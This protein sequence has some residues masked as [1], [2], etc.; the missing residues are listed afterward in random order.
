MFKTT[1]VDSME[2]DAPKGARPC[3]RVRLVEKSPHDSFTQYVYLSCG[4]MRM[5]S[6]R[7]VVGD[8]FDCAQC[9]AYTDPGTIART[10]DQLILLDC[11]HLALTAPARK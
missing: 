8:W 6:A 11:G 10:A 7:I 2:L 9:W 1:I 3:H 5:V 4:H